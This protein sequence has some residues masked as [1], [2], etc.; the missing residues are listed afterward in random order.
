MVLN[1]GML[2]YTIVC[3]P[4]LPSPG[5]VAPSRKQEDK[6]LHLPSLTKVAGFIVKGDNYCIIELCA[7]LPLLLGS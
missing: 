6:S 7:E 2:L 3:D 5:C 4:F 1:I